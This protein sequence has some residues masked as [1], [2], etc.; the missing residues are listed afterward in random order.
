MTWTL[1][2]GLGV[3][4]EAHYGDRVVRCFT[5]RPQNVDALL[6]AALERAPHT[7]AIVSAHDERI[8]Y[9]ELDDIVTRVA[10]N[11]AAL[12]LQRGERIAILLGNQPEFVYTLLAAARMGAI[13]VPLNIREQTPELE[14]ALTQCGAKML[15]HRSELAARL[16]RRAQTP[17]L[18]HLFSVGG[19]ASGSHPFA[20]LLQAHGPAQ[21]FAPPDEEEVAVIL[22][23]SG[24]TGR[25]K[26]AMLTHFGIVHSALHY[27]VCMQLGEGERSLLAVPVSHVTG[28]VAIIATMLRCAGTVVMMQEFKARACLERLAG[29]RITH[30]IMVP[31]MFNLCLLDPQFAE[32]DLSAMRIGGYGGAPMPEAT[33]AALAQRLPNLILVNAY[34]STETTSPVTLMPLGMT[35][36]RPDSVGQTVVCGDLRVMDESGKEVPPGEQGEIW[37]GGPMVVKGYWNNPQATAAAFIGGF[38]RSG[39]IG[40]VDLDGYV[41]VFDRMKDMINRGGYK[42]YS[43][44]VE[45]VLS[46]HPQV[47]ECAVV[48]VADPV[49]GEKTHAF[50]RRRDAGC[51]AQALRAFCAQRLSDYKVPDFFTLQDDPLP[52]NA[53]GKLMKQALRESL[54]AAS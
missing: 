46:H 15:V 13:A 14:Y 32:F 45:N 21:A 6:R 5:P 3:R 34:G 28:V 31:A 26:G 29:E 16:P 19:D 53:N 17:A 39:D 47:I 38:W 49:L 43:V 22:Y 37:L 2:P 4:A 9:A 25:P 35:A 48:P 24:T 27:Q 40:S 36:K 20:R 44:E 23:T 52:R 41:R 10:H 30:T 11:L 50:V 8:R 12:G 1:P 51:D 18:V 54:P 33:I 42:V 7:E